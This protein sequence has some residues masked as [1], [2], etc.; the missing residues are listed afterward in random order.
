MNCSRD[1][2]DTVPKIR[3]IEYQKYASKRE[4]GKVSMKEF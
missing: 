4:N 1:R 2:N 3:K